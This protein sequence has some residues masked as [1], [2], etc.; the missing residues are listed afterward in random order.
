[1]TLEIEWKVGIDIQKFM[2]EWKSCPDTEHFLGIQGH[3]ILKKNPNSGCVRLLEQ[4]STLSLPAALLAN[5]RPPHNLIP[6]AD[7][8]TLVHTTDPRFMSPD[9]PEIRVNSLLNGSQVYDPLMTNGSHSLLP[10]SMKQITIPQVYLNKVSLN[11]WICFYN[12]SSPYHFYS[13]Q[14]WM[15]WSAI[16]VKEKIWQMDKTCE[17]R[18]EPP[19]P[20]YYTV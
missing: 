15:I 20:D 2:N 11:N 1:M 3:P 10:F 8:S 6:Q 12:E 14:D 17:E 13:V 7:D 9:F 4:D 19:F 18:G 5:R 16:D